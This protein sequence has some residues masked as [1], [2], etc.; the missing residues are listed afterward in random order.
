MD[1]KIT[2]SPK[3]QDGIQRLFFLYSQM[4]FQGTTYKVTL[5]LISVDGLN[6]RFM[7]VSA[8]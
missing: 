6:Y 5:M 4:V 3:I 7:V 1:E 8:N 2:Q